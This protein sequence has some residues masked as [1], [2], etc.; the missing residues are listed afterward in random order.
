MNAT[1]VLANYPLTLLLQID[2]GDG[3]VYIAILVLLWFNKILLS[4]FGAKVRL[5]LLNPSYTKNYKKMIERL[6]SMVHAKADMKSGILTGMSAKD[7]ADRL[8][9]SG[10]PNINKRS[11]ERKRRDQ[12]NKAVVGSVLTI[13]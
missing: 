5:H 6:K 10:S 9:N 12:H 13:D 4:Y 8:V 1:A 11:E 7:R 2:F 3:A